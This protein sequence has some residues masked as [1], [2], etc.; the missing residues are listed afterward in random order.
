MDTDK[1][2]DSLNLTIEALKEI[3][4]KQIPF[5]L[6][7]WSVWYI[8]TTIVLSVVWYLI[9]KRTIKDNLGE[10]MLAVFAAV[11]TFLVVAVDLIGLFEVS[12]IIC[13]P[14]W[15]IIKNLIK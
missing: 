7:C 9:Y 11:G 12:Q 5:V 2:L 8:L 15:W 14:D 6:T 13:N 1:V 3:G 4:Y 10:E